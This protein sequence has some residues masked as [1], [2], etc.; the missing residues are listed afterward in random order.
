MNAFIKCSAL[1]FLL[2][3]VAWAQV[4]SSVLLDRACG[5]NNIK[6]KVYE[7]SPPPLQRDQLKSKAAIVIFPE[8]FA[9]LTSCR[10]ASRIGIDG[11]WVGA[12]CLG[13]YIRTKVDPGEHHLCAN[14]RQK[15]NANFTALYS[16]MAEA[17]KVYY[18]REEILDPWFGRNVTPIGGGKITVHLDPINEDE[19]RLLQS[20]RL[21]SES[22]VKK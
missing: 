7:S 17:G 15:K 14:L 16:F 5:P 13:T 2:S 18:F 10:M 1:L 11:K 12:A 22:K 19:G 4:P 9:D 6:F 8:E 21:T 20:I 3:S